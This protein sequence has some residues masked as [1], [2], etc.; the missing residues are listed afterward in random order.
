MQIKLHDVGLIT[1]LVLMAIS[2]GGGYIGGLKSKILGEK[3][4]ASV[5]ITINVDKD[6]DNNMEKDHGRQKD[7]SIQECN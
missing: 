3:D 7:V 4:G 5:E 6:D 2:A 1:L